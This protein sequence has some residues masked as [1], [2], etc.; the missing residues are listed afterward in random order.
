MAPGTERAE[1]LIRARAILL[2]QA[3][4]PAAGE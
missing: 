3:V 1:A 4:I 2:E